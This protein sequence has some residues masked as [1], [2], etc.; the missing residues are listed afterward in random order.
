MEYRQ[1]GHSGLRIPVLSFGT[2]TFGG[3]TE[4]FK[5]WGE[6]DVK[7]AARLVDI[8]LEAG[9]NLF[10]T[11]NVYSQGASEEI[12]GK[13]LAGKRSKALISTKATFPMGAG[14]NDAGSSRYHIIEA[15]EASLKR[16]GSEH[17]DIYFMH[18]FDALTPVEET[19]AALDHL[20]QSGKVR[21][22]GCS[23]FSGWHVMKSLAVSEKYGLARY[24]VYQGYYSLIGR[25]YEWELMPLGLDQGVG[26]MVWSP[27]GWGRLTGKIR[28]GQALPEGRIKSGG[29][30]GGPEVADDYLYKVVDV[31][32]EI[33][34]ETGKSIPQV[35]L[36]WLLQRPTVC[37][38]VIGARNEA[39]LRQNLEAVGWNL[40]SDQIARL[41]KVSDQHPIYP[42][43][44]QAQ[45]EMLQPRRHRS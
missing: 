43:W 10:D 5:T 24:V 21:Y 17:I 16:L 7:E 20:V 11:A 9:V 6:T 36:N 35:A 14:A 39:Q 2:A 8:C 34:N 19:L 28:R 37:N 3:T 12:L 33:A 42:Y 32:D 30:A 23:N 40:T 15:C 27:L 22:I 18:G 26:L 45:F 44:H 13:A 41:D 4:F 29:A 1:L 31:L 38:L 25:E